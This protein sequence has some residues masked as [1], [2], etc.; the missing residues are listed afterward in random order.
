MK[1]LTGT[2][3]LIYYTGNRLEH[4]KLRGFFPASNEGLTLKKSTNDKEGNY[5]ADFFRTNP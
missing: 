3:V 4:V 1:M 5:D 2:V